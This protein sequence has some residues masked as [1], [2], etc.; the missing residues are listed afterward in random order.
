MPLRDGWAPETLLAEAQRVWR[1]AV[2]EM[3]AGEA[4]P[5]SER[6]GVLTVSCS[7][8]VWANELD[9]MALEIIARLNEH[10]GAGK[11]RR[12]RCITAT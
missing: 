11:V 2:G 1:D 9:L 6:A 3:I 8:A 10:L 7:S 5:V 4:G 12:L